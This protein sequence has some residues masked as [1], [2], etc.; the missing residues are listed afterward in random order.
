VARVEQL[1]DGMI[2]GYTMSIQRTER[3]LA[4]FGLER[5]ACAGRAFDPELME[6]VEVVNDSSRPPGQV[7]EEVRPGYRWRGRLFRYAQVSVA[8]DTK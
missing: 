7:V 3:A 6:V 2:T 8:R 4:Q 1:L 5:I